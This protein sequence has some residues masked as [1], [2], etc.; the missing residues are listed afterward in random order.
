MPK[1][2]FCENV[3]G[4][5][6]CGEDNPENF[7]E[8]RYS[9]CKRC[10]NMDVRNRVKAKKEL[11]KDEELERKID[12]L[13]D[14]RKIQLLIENI[15]LDRPLMQ[16]GM[17]IS[18]AIH[19]ITSSISSYRQKDNY[20]VNELTKKVN[21]LEQDNFYLAKNNESLKNQI[22]QIKSFL[23]EKFDKHFEIN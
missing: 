2:Y 15:I 17:T 23:E 12:E 22:N 1:S 18:D 9:R 4:F 6:V 19:N 11:T 5:D 21:K 3:I 7:S 14:G 16:D 13:K 8:G 10:R 20:L